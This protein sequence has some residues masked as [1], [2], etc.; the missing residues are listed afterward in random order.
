MNTKI[1]VALLP[2]GLLAAADAHAQSSVTLYGLISEAI[3]YTNNQKGHSAYQLVTGAPQP[4]RWGMR[5]VE[6][7]GGGNKAIF[8]L[9]NG[10]N[11]NNGTLGQGGR[12]FGRQAYVGL[13]NANWGTL[14]AGR[15]I[16]IMNQTLYAFESATQ[17][18]D[19]VTHIGDNDNIFATY[20]LNNTV[21][22][23][24]AV[25]SGFKVQTQYSFS[26]AA[27]D[28]ANNSEFG[29]GANYTHGP[30]S[31]GAAYEVVRMPASASN[32]SGAVYG[33]YGFTSPFVASVGGAGV[34]KQQS[35]AFGAAYL[36]GK[37]NLSV[38]YSHSKFSYLD[39]TSL[40]LNNYEATG[41]YMVRPDLLLGLSYTFTDGRYSGGGG[42]PKWHQVSGG[43]DY[44]LS[45]RTDISLIGVYQHAA[46]SADIAEIYSLSPS[47]TA[48]QTSVI[49]GMRTKF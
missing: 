23:A 3:A 25:Y 24:S 4:S 49:L 42:H 40:N 9:E 30:L 21:Q 48:S 17:F 12:E 15:Q 8:V 5:G 33:D 16:G 28:F 7:L 13:S 32:T 31:L 11:L 14:T 34:A 36:I 1:L 6:D 47:S 45:K 10:F 29:A 39:A 35:G 2:L 37:A 22:Y 46:G 38:L 44:F 43:V 41:T 18:A 19:F 27:G 20:R 26:N